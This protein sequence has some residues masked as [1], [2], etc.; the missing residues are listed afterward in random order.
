MYNYVYRKNGPRYEIGYRKNGSETMRV[1]AMED[2]CNQ[3]IGSVWDELM[4]RKIV[5]LLEKDH[6]DH[7][8]NAFEYTGTD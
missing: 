5:S 2:W 4:A 7:K 3:R 6:K 8:A 1:D